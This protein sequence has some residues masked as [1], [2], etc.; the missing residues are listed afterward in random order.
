MKA[1]RNKFSPEFRDRAVRPKATTEL[2]IR[3]KGK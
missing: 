3:R 1:A 2:A